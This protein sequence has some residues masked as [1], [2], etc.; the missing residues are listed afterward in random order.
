M[1]FKFYAQSQLLSVDTE[2]R[3][4]FVQHVSENPY[5]IKSAQPYKQQ[6]TTLVANFLLVDPSNKH[7]KSIV[8]VL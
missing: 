5:R 6:N 2:P 1:F 4:L 8:D 3:S 7:R